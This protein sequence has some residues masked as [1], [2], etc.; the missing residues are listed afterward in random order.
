MK[1][2]RYFVGDLALEHTFWIQDEA[3]FHQWTKVLRY[4]PGREVVLFNELHE[5][6]LYKI[7]KIGNNAVQLELVTEFEPKLP[8][9]EVYLGFSLLKKDKSDWVLQKTTELGVRHLVPLLTDRTEKTGFNEERAQKIIIE[10]AEQCERTDIPSLR[11]LITPQQFVDE[12]RDK[13]TIYIAEKSDKKF[14]DLDELPDPVVIM[15]GPEGGWSD[16]E[17]TYFREQQLPLVSLSDFT[18]RA[19]TAAI[20]AVVQ[21]SI[22]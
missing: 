11:S 8:K 1:L 6:R 14:G 16:E 4:Q 7:V 12:M 21:I 2:H 19:E 18:L 20:S 3:L 5:E 17:L 22:I 10:A 9:R 15:I 13:A